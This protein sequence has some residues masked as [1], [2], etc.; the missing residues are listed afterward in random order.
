MVMLRYCDRLLWAMLICGVT[1]AATVS[2]SADELST[3]ELS[4]ILGRGLIPNQMKCDT[5]GYAGA[6]PGA[7]STCE[8]TTQMGGKWCPTCTLP[9]VWDETCCLCSQ[10]LGQCGLCQCHLFFFMSDCTQGLTSGTGC[11]CG[12]KRF[13]K[14]QG[15]I[16]VFACVNVSASTTDLCNSFLD[17]CCT[18]WSTP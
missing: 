17:T 14:C 8:G 16:G 10:D 13:G 2:E 15:I 18:N 3:A 9:A 6:A 12:F 1:M 11:I 5:S 7:A 4:G